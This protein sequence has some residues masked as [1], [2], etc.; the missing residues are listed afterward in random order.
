M[1][2]NNHCPHCNSEF[3]YTDGGNLVCSQCFHEWNPIEE[4]AEVEKIMKILDSN[5]NEL[6]DGDSVI[7]TTNTRAGR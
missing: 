3:T 2:E 4:N 7:I 1:S 5:G 6:S